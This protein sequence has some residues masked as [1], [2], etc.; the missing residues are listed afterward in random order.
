MNANT[1][2]KNVKIHAI[3]CA[4]FDK[5]HA[6]ELTGSTSVALLPILSELLSLKKSFKKFYFFAGG[7]F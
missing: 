3:G 4:D 5:S 6:D 2:N 7:F 1:L